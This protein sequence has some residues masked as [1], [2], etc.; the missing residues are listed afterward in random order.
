MTIITHDGLIREK[1]IY[2]IECASS[3][4]LRDRRTTSLHI[5]SQE[6]V[7]KKENYGNSRVTALS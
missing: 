1:L 4:S 2:A 5:L 6:L 3:A 7:I